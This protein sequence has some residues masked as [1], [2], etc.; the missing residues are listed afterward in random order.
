[1]DPC[2]G[3]RKKAGE[4]AVDHAGREP[5]GMLDTRQTA[6]SSLEDEA[7]FVQR[8]NVENGLVG[9]EKTEAEDIRGRIGTDPERAEGEHRAADKA[10]VVLQ[11]R[12]IESI[13][14]PRVV[15]AA[16]EG[17]GGEGEQ[18]ARN[19]EPQAPQA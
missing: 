8:S 17:G 15:R 7:A 12:R 16:H 18:S 1:D 2:R 4:D 5:L 9:K 3:C 14:G 13:A 19:R 10:K 11:A 6:V